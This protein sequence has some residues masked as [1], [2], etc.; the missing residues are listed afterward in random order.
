MS[1]QTVGARAVG[2]RLRELAAGE[3]HFDRSLAP[4]TTYRVGGAA[5]VLF[6]PASAADL[7]HLRTAVRDVGADPAELG[8]LALGRGSNMVVSDRGFD[9]IVIRTG[10]GLSWI[11]GD[12]QRPT[13]VAAGAATSLPLLANWAARRSLAGLEFT[14]GIPGSV[15]GGVRMNAGAHGGEVADT[16]VSVEVFHLREWGSAQIE[17]AQLDLDYRHSALSDAHLVVAASF[18]LVADEEHAVRSRMESYR[19]HRATT[20]PGAL[21]NAGSTFKNPPGDAAGRL[22]DAAG[23]KGHRV[24]GVQVSELHANFFI[25]SSGATAQDVFDLVHDVR[26]RVLDRFGV[27]LEP[28]VRFVGPFDTAVL[29]EASR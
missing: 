10:A 2:E 16:L 21:Q 8:F 4:L 9:G 15:G 19:R 7:L 13:R 25:A 18:D 29:A 23:L 17:P 24:G 26:K 28:E 11:R 12:E 22:V 6:E 3:V 1:A 5:A 27:D 20:Q 14:V